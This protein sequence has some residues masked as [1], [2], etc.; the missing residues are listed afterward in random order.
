MTLPQ[1]KTEPIAIVGSSCRFPGG[2]NSPSKLWQLLKDPKDVLV[3]IPQS[4]FNPDG[5][6]NTNGEHH[7]VS[8]CDTCQTCRYGSE[9]KLN[10]CQIVE[11]KC[12]A[13]ISLR[14][15]SSRV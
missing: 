9:N 5:F 15:G 3:R 14:R 10:K 13:L 6:Y 1:F 12:I 11:Y 7:G 2:A 8:N 4:R